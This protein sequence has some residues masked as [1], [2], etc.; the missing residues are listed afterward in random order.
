[1]FGVEDAGRWSLLASNIRS[2][3][4]RSQNIR[5]WDLLDEEQ[6]ERLVSIYLQRWGVLFRAVLD[7]EAFAPPWR[8]LRAC[9]RKMELRGALRGGRFV[10]GVGGEQ[11]AFAET[12]DG[13]RRLSK[14]EGSSGKYYSIAATDPVNLLNLVQPSKKLP[15]K[16]NNRV[17]YQDGVPIAVLEA[18]EVRF[19][20]EVGV[21]EQ[22]PLQQALLKR[23][24]PARLRSYLGS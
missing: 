19:L 17:L 12:V 22:W 9:L 3:Q 5:H 16:R 23:N 13:L 24:V 11:F 20:K 6:L 18:G 15:R 2:E 4:S 8:I 10:A 7:R 21:D 14:E 1:M